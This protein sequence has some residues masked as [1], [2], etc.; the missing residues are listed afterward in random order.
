MKRTLAT[1]LAVAGAAAAITV[2]TGCGSGGSADVPT[3]ADMK[4][5]WTIQSSEGF[6]KGKPGGLSPDSRLVITMAKGQGFGGYKTYNDASEGGTTVV[7]ETINGAIGSDGEILYT[8]RDGFFEG[9][10]QDGV[11]TGQYAE[12]GADGTAVNVAYVKK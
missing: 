7:K 10:L 9:V 4:G 5:T 2:A 6:E 1:V 3:G 12:V 11:M 8:D